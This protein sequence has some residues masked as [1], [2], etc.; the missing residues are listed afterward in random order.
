MGDGTRHDYDIGDCRTVDFR[1]PPGRR[2]KLVDAALGRIGGGRPFSTGAYRPAVESISR[3]FDGDVLVHN[4]A[5]AIRSLRRRLPNA[6][7]WL[8][9]HNDLFRTYS[10]TEMRAIADAADGLICVSNYLASQIRPRILGLDHKVS[11]VLNGVDTECFKPTL[12]REPNDLPVILYLGRVVPEK[13]PHLLLQAARQLHREGVA[14]RVKIVGSSNFD[15]NAALT[16]YE[17][18]LRS[19]AADLRGCV[20]FQPFV[21]RSQVVA[22]Y[23]SADIFCAPSDWDDP[24]PLIV[25]EAM[26]CGLATVASSRGGIP[27]EGA[28]AIRYFDPPDVSALAKHIGELLGDDSAR[29]A[30]AAASRKRALEVDWTNTYE[31][32]MN[33]LNPSHEHHG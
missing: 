16:P 26:G 14:H 27:E 28:R 1:S 4:G 2:A 7:I 15:S 20:T 17:Q 8:Y 24:C 13:G 6:S 33:V 18:R 12:N 32:L 3:A 25:L 31:S 30:S 11:V 19:L 29:R 21:P 5:A 22:M 10:N 23:Q 9:C